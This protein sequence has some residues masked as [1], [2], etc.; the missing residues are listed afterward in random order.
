MVQIATSLL[1]AHLVHLIPQTHFFGNKSVLRASTERGKISLHPPG[2][3]LP[4]SSPPRP[5]QA[6]FGSIC[7]SFH[8]AADSSWRQKVDWLAQESSEEGPQLHIYSN[9]SESP[10]S[11][12]ACLCAHSFVVMDA[13]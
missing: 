7:A 2:P 9:C 10:I 4:E 11:L 1:P 12:M 6:L 3:V 8:L 13:T 5:F